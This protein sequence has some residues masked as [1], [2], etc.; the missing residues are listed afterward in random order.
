MPAVGEYLA[1]KYY[2]DQAI[3]KNADELTL[4]RNFHNYIFNDSRLT[5]INSITVNSQTVHDNQV[6][7]KSYV[8]HF[9]QG[10]ERSRRGLGIEIYTESSALANNNQDNIFSNY[11]LTQLKSIRIK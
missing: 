11:K 9:G 5:K 8:D 4:V 3:S 10:T 2:V 1:A 6:I 7:L